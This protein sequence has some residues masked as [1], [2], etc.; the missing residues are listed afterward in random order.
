LFFYNVE[1]PDRKRTVGAVGPLETPA[2]GRLE[3]LGV[4]ALHIQSRLLRPLERKT[5]GLLA[6]LTLEGPTSRSKL[7][8]LLWPASSEATARNNLAQALRRLKQAAGAEKVWGGDVLELQGLL[9]DVAEFQVAHFSGRHLEVVAYQAQLLEGLDYDDC[10]EFEDWLL[11]QREKLAEMRRASLG[12]LAHD[13]EQAGQYREALVYAEGLLESDALSEVAYRQVMRL[14]YLLGDRSAALAVFERCQAILLREMGVAPLPQTQELRQQIERGELLVPAIPA[15]RPEIPLAVLRPPRLLGREAEWARM[16]A[17]WEKGQGLLIAGAPGVGKSRLLQDF[18]HSRGP[19]LLFEGRPGDQ[20]IPYATYSRLCRG[21]LEHFPGLALPDWVRQEL[22]RLL[23]ELGPAQPPI[24]SRAEKLRFFQAS[25]ELVRLALAEG[26]GRLAVDDLQFADMASLEL[27]HFVLSPYWGQPGA[28]AT[29]LAF[30]AGE[31]PDWMAALLEQ[32]IQGGQA[33]QIGLQPLDVLAVQGLLASLE[34]PSLQDDVPGWAAALVRHTGGNPFFLLETLR[35]LWESGGLGQPRPGRLPLSSKI[36]TLIQA[37]L[38]RLSPEALRLVRTAAVA[39]PDFS[40]ELA[41]AALQTTPL[42]LLPP[43][44]ELEAAQLLRGNAFTHDLLYEATRSGV[45]A[46][47]KTYLHQQT[48]RYLESVQA[49]PARIANH[50][51]EGEPSRAIPF[52]I[53]AARWAENAYQLLEAAHFYQRAIEIAERHGD[54]T[55]TF[56]LLEALSGVMGRYD[57]GSQHEAL[58]QRMLNIARTPEQ[59]A[60]A[61]LCEAIRLGEHGFGAEAEQAARKGLHHIQDI[62][63]PELHIRM[64]DALAQALFVQRKATDLIAA[65]DQ[66]RDIHQVR[67]DE[68]Q[69]AICTSRL[70]IAYD[71]LERHREA[72]AYYQAAGPV[73]ERSENRLMRVGFHH[74][75]GVCLAALG[76]AEAALEAQLQAGRL[77]EGMQ[78]VVGRLV[79]HCNNLALRYHD[80]ERYREAHQALEQALQIVPEEW[81]WTRAFSEY[82]MARL[83]YVWGAWA[84]ASDW[85]GRALGQPDLPRRDEATYRI[86]GLLLAHRRGEETG[87]WIKKLNELFS[88]EQSQAYGRFLLAQSRV[89]P[90]KQ[91]LKSLQEALKLAQQN[92]WP[93][94]LA[95]THTLYAQALLQARRPHEAL[96]HTQSAMRLLQTYWPAG[97]SRL[98]VLWT[99]HRA[100]AA[101]H[102]SDNALLRQ[103]LDHLLQVAE[104]HVPPQHRHGFLRQ[105]SLSREILEAAQTAGI[106]TS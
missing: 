2:R 99:H 49:D 83:H 90:P 5:A 61:W 67:G 39:G 78:G 87:P 88:G 3:L 106:A 37:R 16:E 38:E 21:V 32:A 10:P 17:A 50:W 92:D 18:L 101:H 77:L 33:V 53:Q 105:N 100:Q 52:L 102:Q 63:R 104:N 86:L 19:A 13:L 65:L 89:L 22:A 57:T 20:G 1:V 42:A 34:L 59:Q 91:A 70:G 29:V 28:L 58:I 27:L 54:E 30:R 71:Q 43:W 46:S 85:L 72:L 56:D 64:L 7:A 97:C 103:V 45:P 41:A 81:G 26:L 84:L 15:Q 12:A 4:P 9:V 47:I 79:H 66:L 95:A 24:Q 69:A 76:L 51:L 98:E 6:Y 8:G 48:A 35:S 23:P 14:L 80:L 55:Q 40:P 60:R 36:S 94:L 62:D 73:L 11:V 68:L 93:A 82:Q 74:N 44:A 25:A 96:G 31:L 75:R